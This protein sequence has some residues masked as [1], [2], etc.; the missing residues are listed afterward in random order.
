MFNFLAPLK[1]YSEEEPRCIWKTG[2]EN[3]TVF[4][5]GKKKSQQVV[6]VL[7]PEF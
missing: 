6:A 2:N 5:K 1:A 4:K 7:I 3:T